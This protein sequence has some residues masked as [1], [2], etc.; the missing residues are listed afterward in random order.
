[1]MQQSS[2]DSN[3]KESRVDVL[4]SALQVIKKIPVGGTLLVSIAAKRNP[5]LF[6]W[7]VKKLID[8]GW[9]E[10]EFTNDYKAIKRLDLPNHAIDYFNALPA[11]S[12]LQRAEIK[13]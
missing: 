6:I 3:I 7:A 9:K 11:L 5:S 2:K 13:K 4:F 8:A 12:K 1:M 10:F